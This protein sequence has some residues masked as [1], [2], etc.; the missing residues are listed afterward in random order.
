MSKAK[1][2]SL[3]LWLITIGLLI[4]TGYRSFHLVASTL[5]ADA[6]ILGFAAL[7]ALD[8][9][10]LAWVDFVHKARGMQVTIAHLMVVVDLVGVGAAL[11][12][13][14]LLIASTGYRDLVGVIAT[15]VVPLVILANVAATIFCKVIDPAKRLEAA[16]RDVDAETEEAVIAQLANRRGQIAAHVSNHVA[17]AKQRELIAAWF[18]GVDRPGDGR[19]GIRELTDAPRA[20]AMPVFAPPA[21]GGKNGTGGVPPLA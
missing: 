14:T 5:P 10:L 11:L 17:D 16:Q 8:L 7:A 13:D 15:W 6:Q 9:G 1:N 21:A 19:A 4:Y 20:A 12:A 3:V 18:A 2:N